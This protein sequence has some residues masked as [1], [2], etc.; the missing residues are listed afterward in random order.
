MPIII[1]LIALIRLQ[2]INKNNYMPT[3]IINQLTNKQNLYLIT[4]TTATST[5][6][7]FRQTAA[8][9]VADFN[10]TVATLPITY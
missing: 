6:L 9:L 8:I 1:I 4:I 5:V 7:L 3:P 10:L 2:S